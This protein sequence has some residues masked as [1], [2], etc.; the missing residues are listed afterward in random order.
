MLNISKCHLF[1]PQNDSNNKRRGYLPYYS[2]E[3]LELPV[4]NNKQKPTPIDIAFPYG[5]VHTTDVGVSCSLPSGL[6]F[7]RFQLKIILLN[8]LYY[9]S[10]KVA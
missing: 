9:M 8:A 1:N 6:K 5:I 10:A 4:P 2:T 7:S 3:A